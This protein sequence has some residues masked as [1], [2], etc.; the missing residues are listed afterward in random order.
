[1]E[2]VDYGEA[3]RLIADLDTAIDSERSRLAA[4]NPL[5]RRL[6]KV[7]P[8]LGD[9][10]NKL[11]DYLSNSREAAV[12]MEVNRYP[13]KPRRGDLPLMS[14]TDKTLTEIFKNKLK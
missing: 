10:M 2:E 9:K 4:M 5:R 6:S 7:T 14:E 1:M 13:F 12:I 3:L 8:M 11:V